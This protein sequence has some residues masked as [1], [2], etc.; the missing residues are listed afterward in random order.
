MCLLGKKT[1]EHVA[2]PRDSDASE[3]E[4]GSPTGGYIQPIQS[5]QH[6]TQL[7]P[8]MCREVQVLQ[9][10][11]AGP[12]SES[13]CETSSALATCAAPRPPAAQLSGPARRHMQQAR[14]DALAPAAECGVDLAQTD[15]QPEAMQ[16]ADYGVDGLGMPR[17]HGAPQP[18]PHGI[19]VRS[20]GFRVSSFDLH[21]PASRKH[22][23]QRLNS[24]WL[25]QSANGSCASEL[26]VTGVWGQGLE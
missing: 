19:S 11:R 8:D 1:H 16:H 15:L 10:K 25:E 2:T 22:T 20:G 13:S 12:S 14:D 5:I 17:L 23:A 9:R 3:G 7:L 6:L 26:E 21:S 24:T 4:R 18:V